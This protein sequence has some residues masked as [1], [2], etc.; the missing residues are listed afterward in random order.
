V[1]VARKGFEYLGQKE[2]AGLRVL[3]R[4]AGL[5]LHKLLVEAGD[6]AE[7]EKGDQAGPCAFE[8]LYHKHSRQIFEC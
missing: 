6:Q 3:L 4:S 1:F 7:Q 2:A 8:G 5:R